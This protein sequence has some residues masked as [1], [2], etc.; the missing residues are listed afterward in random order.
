[1]RELVS[2]L[3]LD[4]DGGT[5]EEDREEDHEDLLPE[6]VRPKR[7]SMLAAGAFGSEKLKSGRPRMHF[8]GTVAFNKAK[9]D[10]EQWQVQRKGREEL[11]G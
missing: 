10:L 4:T 8:T 7:L 3:R 9:E 5:W 11:T 1:V 2:V 6:T